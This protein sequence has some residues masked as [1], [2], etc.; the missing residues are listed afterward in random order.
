MTLG[1]IFSKVKWYTALAVASG[2]LGRCVQKSVSSCLE[3]TRLTFS[4][5]TAK[6]QT[7]TLH[8]DKL[9]KTKCDDEDHIKDHKHRILASTKAFK[10][11]SWSASVKWMAF[12]KIC[13]YLQKIQQ[14]KN[15]TT[16]SPNEWAL[17]ELRQWK[18]DTIHDEA[19]SKTLNNP[20][21]L[22]YHLYNGQYCSVKSKHAHVLD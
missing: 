13:R 3:M 12:S 10:D 15:Y 7:E 6:D 9:L 17:A 1:W 20:M 16:F 21:H 19:L 8:Q 5:T 14:V 2:R 4:L 11:S 18:W 22:K